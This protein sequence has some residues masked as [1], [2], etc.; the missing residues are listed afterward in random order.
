[1]W[2]GCASQLNRNHFGQAIQQDTHQ[3]RPEI[4]SP[5]RGPVAIIDPSSYRLLCGR[6]QQQLT[7][8]SFSDGVFLLIDVVDGNKEVLGVLQC[9][10][11]FLMKVV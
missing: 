11:T 9:I 10:R 5:M 8:V 6:F 4:A 1:V 3:L 7:S 2:F